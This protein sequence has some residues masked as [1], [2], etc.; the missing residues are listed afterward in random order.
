MCHYCRK[1]TGC[2]SESHAKTAKLEWKRKKQSKRLQKTSPYFE[3]ALKQADRDKDE[4]HSEPVT[5][6][7]VDE[8]TR[9]KQ[10]GEEHEREKLAYEYTLDRVAVCEA[11]VA[12]SM[13]SG[14]T[15]STCVK[16]H[17]HLLYPHFSPPQSPFGLVQE[18]LFNEPWKLLVATIFLNKTTGILCPCVCVLCVL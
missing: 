9:P 10:A 5:P 4:K 2:P 7:Q 3:T 16:R 14:S 1:A 13:P 6:L 17:R 8:E 11:P 12:C 15:E 18:Q